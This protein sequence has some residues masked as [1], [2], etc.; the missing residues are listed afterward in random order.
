MS[1][2]PIRILYVQGKYGLLS[3]IGFWVEKSTGQGAGK[4]RKL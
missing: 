2:C 1:L 4:L 3:A